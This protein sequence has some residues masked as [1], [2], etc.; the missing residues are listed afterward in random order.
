MQYKTKTAAVAIPHLIVVINKRQ[1]YI[2][3]HSSNLHDTSDVG[4]LP[5]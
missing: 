5:F 4:Y 2:Y 1:Q 3:H